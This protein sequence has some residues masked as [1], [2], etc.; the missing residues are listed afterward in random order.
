MQR[1]RIHQPVT[2]GGDG[3]VIDGQRN[4]AEII[5]PCRIEDIR[6]EIGVNRHENAAIFITRFAYPQRQ[7]RALRHHRRARQNGHIKGFADINGRDQLGEGGIH[8]AG[9]RGAKGH[10]VFDQQKG[11]DVRAESGMGG[12]P[13]VNIL[14]GLVHQRLQAVD[15]LPQVVKVA[16]Q[17]GINVVDNGVETLRP[18][19]VNHHKLNAA[20]Q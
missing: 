7:R 5:L 15:G 10:A 20:G 2:E 6:C 4:A 19:M 18:V 12:E 3:G 16:L 17:I 14:A 1:L 8:G 13:G 11:A 9:C